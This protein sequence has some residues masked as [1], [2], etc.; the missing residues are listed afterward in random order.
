MSSVCLG[1]VS[2]SASHHGGEI[3]RVVPTILNILS[4]RVGWGEMGGFYVLPDPCTDVGP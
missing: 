2:E 4:G 1:T 3:I